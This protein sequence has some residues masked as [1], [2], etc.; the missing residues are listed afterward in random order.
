MRTAVI[1]HYFELNSTYKENFIFFL[2][3]AI[4]PDVNYFIYI[5]GSCSV[6]LADLP[7]LHYIGIENKNNDF[8]GLVEFHK[9]NRDIEYDNYIIV[10]SSMRGPFLPNYFMADW[11][12]I[13]ISRLSNRTGI[14]GSS[15][16]F[17]PIDSFHSRHFREIYDYDPPYVHVQ[18]TAYALSLSA[19]QLLSQK[20]F[21]DLA[22]NLNK[23]DLITRY[24]ILLSQLLLHNGFKITSI[25]P[26][27]E[28]FS[29][30]HNKLGFQGTDKSGDV[31]FKSAYYGRTLN[32]HESLFIKT[33]RNIL[34]AVE[35]ASYTFTG[36]LKNNVEGF[37]T[38]DGAK[39]FESSS[40]MILDQS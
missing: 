30:Q 19:Y 5:S 6:E 33:N 34:T 8:G 21:F 39:L 15:I 26:T 1:Y 29:A 11:C 18:T 40:G 32:P 4:K 28:E 22:E 13:F 38:R 7:N 12:S 24:E 16:N 20:G 35:L 27:F 3:T 9:A 31:L 17:L 2:N 36:L 23:N 37:T 25:L 14:V 10:N